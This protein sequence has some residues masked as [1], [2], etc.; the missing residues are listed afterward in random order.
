MELIRM[1]TRLVFCAAAYLA[2]HPMC[3]ESAETGDSLAIS[4]A[5]V[6]DHDVRVHTVKSPYQS[7]ETKIR[8]L[9]PRDREEGKPLPV[10]YVLPVEAGDG[11]RWG[12]SVAEVLKL[13]LHNRH[14]LICVFPTFSALPWYAD[15]P[16]DPALRQ[17]S[18]LLE[19]VVPYVE[20]T[21]QAAATKEGRL[22]VG[23]SKSG[24]GAYT[25]LMRYP[26]LFAKAAA[27]DAPLMTAEPTRYGMGPIFGTQENF[28]KYRVTSL[29]KQRA[30]LLRK[31]SRLVLTG[32]GGFRRQHEEAHAL[33]E[34]LK[35]PHEYR[36]GPQR[37]HSWNS[38]WLAEAVEL[39]LQPPP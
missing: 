36:D 14:Q 30:P 16:T 38:G 6:E 28:E 11:Q 37:E 12:D 9:L 10:L 13:D 33:M 22:L 2:L 35:I 4:E 27:W 24:Y 39:L 15:H 29:L 26:E 25:L 5:T 23:F 19:A 31:S 8:V 20:K 34:Q 32:Y 1:S 7:G 3:G 17:E 18:Y 21:Y